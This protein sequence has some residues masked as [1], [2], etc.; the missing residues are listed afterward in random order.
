MAVLPQ[1]RLSEVGD[2]FHRRILR[3]VAARVD[4]SG[5][6]VVVHGSALWGDRSRLRTG[7]PIS[8]VD[9]LVIGESIDHL[10]CAARE[11]VAPS[12]SIAEEGIPFLKLS[13]KFRTYSELTPEQLTANEVGAIR[14]GRRICGRSR[15]CLPRLCLSWFRDQAVLA[16]RTRL[17]Y[18]AKQQSQAFGHWA[19]TAL[20]RY[21]AA[22]VVLDIP[23]IGLLMSGTTGH[24]LS[25]RVRRF[26]ENGLRQLGLN[27]AEEASLISLLRRAIKVKR[28]PD[29]HSF[30][31][32]AESIL[33]FRRLAAALTACSESILFTSLAWA[34]ERP[35]DLRD[36]AIW[37]DALQECAS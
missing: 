13:A 36:R 2:K 9:L 8:D 11:L 21:L 16:A 34:S 23:T 30:I 26:G 20:L 18:V 12:R 7:L 24:S 32:L 4:S 1:L 25:W 33:L 35:L 37:R 10:Q 22:R 31:E 27:P 15:I 6:S 14:L 17:A 29:L 28:E 5:C 19:E 3:D